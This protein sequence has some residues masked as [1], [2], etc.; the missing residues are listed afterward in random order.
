[1]CWI[2]TIIFG[3]IDSEEYLKGFNLKRFP[4]II[5]WKVGWVGGE[6]GRTGREYINSQKEIIK[7]NVR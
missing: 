2:L 3:I 7:D 4:K 1:M 6:D 5:G